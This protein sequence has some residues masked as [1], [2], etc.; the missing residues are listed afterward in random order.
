V[1]GAL[2]PDALSAVALR[3][4]PDLTTTD[5]AAAM[6]T[7]AGTARSMGVVIRP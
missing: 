7:V 2:G 5:L 3:N 1:D 4:L 6:R